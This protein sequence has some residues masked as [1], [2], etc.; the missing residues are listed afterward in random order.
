MRSSH[1]VLPVSAAAILVAGSVLI[2]QESSDDPFGGATTQEAIPFDSAEKAA[3]QR[4][5]P[6]PVSAPIIW[7]HQSSNAGHIHQVLA[8]KL[9]STGLDFPE[10]ELEEVVDFL[11]NEYE[12]PI[13]IDYAA[14]DE[15]GISPGDPVDVN[16]EDISLS[17][18]LRIMLRPLDLTTMIEDEVLLITTEEY[19]ETRLLVGVHPVGDLLTD[20]SG[21]EELIEVLL[22]TVASESWAENGGGEAEIRPFNGMLVISQTQAVHEQLSETL[23]ALRKAKR[24]PSSRMT[25]DTKRLQVRGYQLSIASEQIE[26]GQV[27]KVMEL[28]AQTIPSLSTVESEAAKEAS[29]TQMRLLDNKLIVLANV[30]T[31]SQVKRTLQDAGL[32][33]TGGGSFCGGGSHGGYSGG[34]GGQFSV[35][36]ER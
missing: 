25:A 21:G 30:A 4:A 29:E 10:T 15:L 14:L 33:K 7:A 31:H 12:I 27:A 6:S 23:N 18:A 20:L 35:S 36:N 8:N 22:S 17:S 1:F 34:G 11:R 5:E 26:P 32:I 3:E 24:H 19:A 9:T 16:V 13:Q 28:V 2:G